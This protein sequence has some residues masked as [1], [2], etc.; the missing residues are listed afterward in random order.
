M[1]SRKG[2]LTSS[3]YSRLIPLAA[4]YNILLNAPSKIPILT[5][6]K[7]PS[8]YLSFE[9]FHSL[10]TRNNLKGATRTSK[11]WYYHLQSYYHWTY[12]HKNSCPRMIN[13]RLKRV[14]VFHL[15]HEYSVC[16]SKLDMNTL[17][18]LHYMNN[19]NCLMF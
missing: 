12:C 11:R 17:F 1:S 3:R 8:I 14:S 4:V 19:D 15:L 5:F 13:L 7:F 6:S 10:A 18:C 9:K 2:W 16:K